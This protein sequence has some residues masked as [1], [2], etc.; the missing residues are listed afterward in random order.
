M[1]PIPETTGLDIAF[2]NIDY[3][4]IYKDVPDQFK[5]WNEPHSEF[6]SKWFFKG[7]DETKIRVKPGV[8]KDKALA[9]IYAALSSWA[10]KHE[11]KIAGCA[12]MLSEWFDLVLDSN[13]ETKEK[14]NG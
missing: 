14:R 13:N 7:L 9:A 8:D 11:H 5:S 4:P 1:L 3:M 2:G 6:I 10:P 12:Y